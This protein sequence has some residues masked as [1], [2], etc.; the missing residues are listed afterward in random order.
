M[1]GIKNVKFA[2]DVSNQFKSKFV[3]VLLIIVLIS[4]LF[5]L[6]LAKTLYWVLPMLI[7][8]ICLFIIFIKTLFLWYTKPYDSI[9]YKGIGGR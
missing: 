4:L 2:I 1:S 7:A 9:S 6:I 5:A 8:S 3:K